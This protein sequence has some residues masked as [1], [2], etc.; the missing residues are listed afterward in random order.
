MDIYPLRITL[1]CI[2][3]HAYLP[4]YTSSYHEIIWDIQ[5]LLEMDKRQG[6]ELELTKMQLAMTQAQ[7]VTS[8]WKDKYDFIITQGIALSH[9]LL[10]Y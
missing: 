4:S 3:P 8:E 5:R 2:Y 1:L 7:S 6:L 9:T 10:I